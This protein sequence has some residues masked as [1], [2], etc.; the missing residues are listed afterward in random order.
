MLEELDTKNLVKRPRALGNVNAVGPGDSSPVLVTRL[1]KELSA[2]YT[3]KLEAFSWLADSDSWLVDVLFER[4][5]QYRLARRWCARHGGDYNTDGTIKP[6]ALRGDKHLSAVTQTLEELG[7]APAARMA[8]GLQAIVGDDL[9][10][11]A[12]KMRIRS[13]VK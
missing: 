3:G 8:M 12:Q 11:R 1:A 6:A 7:G 4:I 13:G 2:K 5:A 10:A 9:A